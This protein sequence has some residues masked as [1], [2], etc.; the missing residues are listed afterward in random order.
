MVRQIP[1]TA[2]SRELLEQRDGVL[3]EVKRCDLPNVQAFGSI[4]IGDAN[5][6]SDIDLLVSTVPNA[7][8]GFEMY[9]LTEFVAKLTGRKVD[10]LFDDRMELK[11]A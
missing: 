10:M 5:E 1:L 2:H 11:D 7:K 6:N 4:A 8:L 3:E 9:G